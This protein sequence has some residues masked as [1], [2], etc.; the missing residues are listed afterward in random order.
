MPRTGLRPCGD[1]QKVERI[2]LRP[3]GD[4]QKSS[5]PPVL[6]ETGKLV[7]PYKSK[8]NA[9][10]CPARDSGCW[11][12]Y[13]RHRNLGARTQPSHPAGEYD[14]RREVCSTLIPDSHSGVILGGSHYAW[15]GGNLRCGGSHNL[16]G[17]GA[18]V[19]SRTWFYDPRRRLTT[20]S[21]KGFRHT[22]TVV[23]A[24]DPVHTPPEVLLSY[25][26]ILH[27]YFP[28]RTYIQRWC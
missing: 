20:V 22:A 2:G 26:D 4:N 5:P 1:I 10:L 9:L 24:T 27:A 18:C 19:N 12:L 11:V 25:P 23:S 16:R 28:Y 3:C 21:T 13:K 6:G 14:G 7:K 17:K 15:P 8:A